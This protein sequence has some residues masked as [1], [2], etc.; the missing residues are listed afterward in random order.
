MKD[1]HGAIDIHAAQADHTARDATKGIHQLHRLAARAENEIYDDVKFLPAEF[2]LMVLEKLAVA[3]D[4]ARA[5]RDGCSTAMENSDGMASGK[6]LLRC[7]LS[8][9]A[10]TAD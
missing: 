7:E 8:D 10:G 2:E 1:A 6:K 3:E 4:L 5:L 9:E